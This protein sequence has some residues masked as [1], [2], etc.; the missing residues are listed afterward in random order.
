MDYLKLSCDFMTTV[1]DIK[2]KLK[3][4][5]TTSQKVNLFDLNLNDK[6]TILL[7]FKD[8]LDNRFKIWVFTNSLKLEIPLKTSL[9]FSINIPDKV[10]LADKKLKDIKEIGKIYTDNS[11]NDLIINCIELLKGDLRT[12]D[13]YNNEGLTVYGNLLQLT[14]NNNRQLLP[15]IE[16]CKK[17]KMIIESNFP[18]KVKEPDYSDLPTNL[19]QI[20]LKFEHL[21][22][23]D[24]FERDELIDRLSTKQRKDI[25]KAIESKFEEI[26]LFLD[27]FGDK[28]LTEGA[29]RLQCL[30]EIAI[31]LT[32]DGKKN[33]S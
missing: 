15:E 29:I 28:P 27:T 9:L 5:R 1:Q 33:H 18:G 7:K 3:M 25:I 2:N 14:L 12:L 26:N 13:F 11:K 8:N 16:V 19:K 4:F 21:G 24:D 22:V 31:E 6:S 23:T 30:A 10:C 32:N 17:L 20:L